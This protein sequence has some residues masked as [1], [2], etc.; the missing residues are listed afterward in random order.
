MRRSRRTTTA[1]LG[2]AVVVAAGWI[3]VP[4]IAMARRGTL[5]DQRVASWEDVPGPTPAIPLPRRPPAI[6]RSRAL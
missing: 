6:E 4:W 1:V 5:D 3:T 2:A